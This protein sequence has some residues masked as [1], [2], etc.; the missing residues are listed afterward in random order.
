MSCLVL[1]TV[2]QSPRQTPTNVTSII[3]TLQP[4]HLHH[5]ARIQIWCQLPINLIQLV[6]TGSEEVEQDT[7]KNSGQDARSQHFSLALQPE[8]G[9]SRFL[10]CLPHFLASP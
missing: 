1:C 7:G 9:G 6:L 2:G 8:M 4:N 3:P 5:H 10:S